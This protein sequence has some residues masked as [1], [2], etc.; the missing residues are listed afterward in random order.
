MLA[1]LYVFL[2]IPGAEPVPTK[3]VGGRLER[4]G[5]PYV[6]KGAGG[7]GSPALLAQLG[8]N[9]TRTWGA[10]R[11]GEVLDEAHKHEL[12]V[13]LGIWLG[14]ERHGFRYD[15]P[16]Q[17]EA[18]REKAREVILRYKDHPALLMWGLG[19]E[20]EGYGSG[21]D[22]AIWKAVEEV[23]AMAHSLDKDHPTMTVVA[24]IGGGRVGAIHKFCPSI[25]VVGINSYAGAASIPAR[26]RKVGG[27]KPYILTEFGPDGFWESPKTAWGAPIE[28]GDAAKVGTYRRTYI[29]NRDEPLCLGSYAFLWGSK[30]EAT[31]TWFGMLLRS[32]ERTA[33]ADAMGELWSGRPPANRAPT[34]SALKLQGGGRCRPGAALQVSTTAADPEGDPVSLAWELRREGGG[35]AGGDAEPVPG[36]YPAAIAEARAD[37]V[38]LTMPGRPGPYRLF[39]VARDGQGGAAVA[40]LPLLVEQ[41]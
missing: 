20:M 23:A 38:R 31:G 26:Y 41:P 9:S 12:T 24:E 25:D 39:A 37:G 4:G 36:S 29:S 14:H 32:G 3:V 34:L 30:Q 11:A 16:K 21:D 5:R 13:T 2:A 6:V 1:L 18:Q 28:P 40:N 8:G 10:D 19:N 35:G 7:D 15:D 33:A 17:V 27:T 22:P